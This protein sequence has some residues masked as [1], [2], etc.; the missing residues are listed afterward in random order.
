MKRHIDQERDVQEALLKLIERL[1]PYLD[2]VQYGSE[3]FR[4]IEKIE[5]IIKKP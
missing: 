4:R 5:E 1:I 3:C 2:Q